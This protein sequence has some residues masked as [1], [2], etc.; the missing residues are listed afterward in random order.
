MVIAAMVITSSMYAQC[1][2]FSK[3]KCSPKIKPYLNTEQLYS[4]TM[5]QGDK[6][7][8][9]TTFYYGDDY[10][11]VVCAVEKLGKIELNLR[12]ANNDVVFTTKG[13]GNITWDFNVQTTQDFTIEITTPP[14][15]GESLDA[16]GCVS[17]II[18]H[19]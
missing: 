12:D 5:L 17:V 18:G 16:S 2:A 10:R 7:E 9:K 19:K 11:I 14:G 4:S 1:S 13:Y 3:L 6:T 8:V 15:T